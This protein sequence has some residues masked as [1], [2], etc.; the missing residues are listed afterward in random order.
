MDRVRVRVLANTHKRSYWF[1]VFV[2]CFARSSSVL[3]VDNHD[4]AVP[5]LSKHSSLVYSVTLLV[6]YGDTETKKRHVP[7]GSVRV[8][9][10]VPMHKISACSVFFL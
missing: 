9:F 4:A 2:F 8:V 5:P 6:V 1:C 3:V 7:P 10:S